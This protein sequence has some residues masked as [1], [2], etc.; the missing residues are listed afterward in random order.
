[1]LTAVAVWDHRP[2]P[3]ELLDQ[4]LGSGWRPTPTRL[5]EGPR[6]LG[7]AACRVDGVVAQQIRDDGIR[8]GS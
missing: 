1:V 4:R 3:D 7:H 2:T 8:P 6:I 5:K